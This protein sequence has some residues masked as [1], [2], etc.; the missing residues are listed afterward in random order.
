MRA[1]RDYVAFIE[2]GAFRTDE[3]GACVVKLISAE[4]GLPEAAIR[5]I[6]PSPIN[7]ETPLNIA[8]LRK[9]LEFMKGQ[10]DV[11]DAG[12]SVERLVDLS[13]YDAALKALA[14]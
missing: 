8:G 9:D 3:R 2:N 5:G 14:R 10:G 1:W 13:I 11:I 7:I 6:R 4:T 12:M